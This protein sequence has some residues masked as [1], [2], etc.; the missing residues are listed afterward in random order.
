MD[1]PGWTTNLPDIFQN[2]FNEIKK[3]LE[4]VIQTLLGTEPK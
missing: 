4:I 3:L 1:L 2:F